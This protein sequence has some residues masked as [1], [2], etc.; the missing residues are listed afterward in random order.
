MG[1]GLRNPIFLEKSD[2]WAEGLD[3]ARAILRDRLG[4]VDRAVLMD[5]PRQIKKCAGAIGSRY[6]VNPVRR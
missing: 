3:S 5:S 1:F 2:F 4:L 6:N